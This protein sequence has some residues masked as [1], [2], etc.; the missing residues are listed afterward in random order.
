MGTIPKGENMTLPNIALIGR[1]RS[2]KDTAAKHL[3]KYHGYIPM[4]FA[5]PLRKMA[6]EIDPLIPAENGEHV[7]LRPLI[8][9]AGWEYAKVRYPEV[10]RILQHVGQ[11]IR[12][13]D[14]D[15]WASRLMRRVEVEASWND[16]PVVVT[17]VRYRNEAEALSDA[18]F[19]LVRIVRP[20]LPNQTGAEH[21]SETA[22]N[23]FRAD[24]V[25][26]NDSTPEL[27]GYRL[28]GYIHA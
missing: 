8:E 28:T 21:E 26:R 6:L 10:R 15:Y 3:R 18:G 1:S 27:L 5:D 25:I 22:L 2:G 23:N 20:S 16:R 11:S 7:R 17:D 19:R 4:A 9:F 24:A 14:P 13:R 12:D